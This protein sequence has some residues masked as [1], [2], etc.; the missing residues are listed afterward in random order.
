MMQ[1]LQLLFHNYTKE[2]Q[3][4]KSTQEDSPTRKLR[5]WNYWQIIISKIVQKQ[6]VYVCISIVKI[7]YNLS[8]NLLK[9]LQVNMVILALIKQK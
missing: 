3:V 7:L 8:V 9:Q 1:I 6:S 4:D 5:R 2:L